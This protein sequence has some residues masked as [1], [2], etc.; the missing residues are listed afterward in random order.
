EEDRRALGIV[1]GLLRLSVGIEDTAD[2]A[3][4]FRRAL[5]GLEA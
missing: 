1:P 4:D 5:E 3:A 2:L